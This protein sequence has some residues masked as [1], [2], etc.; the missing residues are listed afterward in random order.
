MGGNVFLCN[1]SLMSYIYAIHIFRFS[2]NKRLFLA[3][4]NKISCDAETDSGIT[5]RC[6]S[7]GSQS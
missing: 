6:V 4:Q 3:I 5:E 2:Q 7:T 1:K